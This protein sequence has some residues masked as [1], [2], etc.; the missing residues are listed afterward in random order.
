VGNGKI[1]S[2]HPEASSIFTTHTD[3][4]GKEKDITLGTV[5]FKKWVEE[6]VPVK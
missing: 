3:A 5:V 6:K 4:G 1:K 2:G